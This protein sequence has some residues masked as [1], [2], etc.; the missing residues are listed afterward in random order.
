MSLTL[1]A[2]L[3]SDLSLL[4]VV[5]DDK[6]EKL[7]GLVSLTLRGEN[8][9]TLAFANELDCDE[10]E[11]QTGLDAL[12]YVIAELVRLSVTHEVHTCSPQRVV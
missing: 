3:R 6:A 1:S 11:L 12:C 9:D 8:P 10:G 2:E 7:A 4:G 5:S